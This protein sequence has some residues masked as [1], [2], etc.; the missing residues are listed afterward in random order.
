MVSNLPGSS[1]HGGF[2]QARILVEWVV[3]F[4][5]RGSSQLRGQTHVSW[6]AGRFFTS[7][8]PGKPSFVVDDT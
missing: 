2:F 4:S 6:L 7:E 1:V 5:S 8:P 3:I